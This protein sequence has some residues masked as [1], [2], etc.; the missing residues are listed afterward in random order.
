MMGY[1]RCWCDGLLPADVCCVVLT[2]GQGLWYA[3]WHQVDCT[4]LWWPSTAVVVCICIGD[5]VRAGSHWLAVS[6]RVA[7]L[8]RRQPLCCSL[9]PS[10]N[11][12]AL[13]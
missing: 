8:P 9:S 2:A 13:V 6:A 11:Q 1:E 7:L 4:A 5:D 12:S 3:G 10:G